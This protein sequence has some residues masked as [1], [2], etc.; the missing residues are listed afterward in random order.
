MSHSKK[1]NRYQISF[2]ENIQE[3]ELMDHMLKQSEI[4][5]ISAYVKMLIR[6][7]LEEYKNKE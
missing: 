3:L 2:K 7:D 1:G 5:G 4:M 6:K